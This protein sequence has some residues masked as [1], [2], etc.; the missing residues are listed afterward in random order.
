[1][2]RVDERWYLLS[3][4]TVKDRP[5]TTNTVLSRCHGQPQTSIHPTCTVT[6]MTFKS[7]VRM[8]STVSRW[9]WKEWSHWSK[10]VYETFCYLMKTGALSS[11]STIIDRLIGI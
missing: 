4:L 9:K 6:G 11:A 1:M 5:Q 8:Y 3:S 10:R 2:E 7:V